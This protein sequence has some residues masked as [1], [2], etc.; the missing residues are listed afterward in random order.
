M[1][2]DQTAQAEANALWLKAQ[3]IRQLADAGY[4]RTSIVEAVSAGDLSKLKN[5][6]R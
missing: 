5:N 1:T 3:A 4:E 2:T 6:P